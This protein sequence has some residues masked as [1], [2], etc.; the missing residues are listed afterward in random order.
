MAVSRKLFSTS[1]TDLIAE[2]D[3][4]LKECNHLF[5]LLNQ[6]A[7]TI[8]QHI[9]NKQ[10]KEKIMHEFKSWLNE[11]ESYQLH[12][13]KTERLLLTDKDWSDFNIIAKKRD[14]T[15]QEFKQ[16]VNLNLSGRNTEFDNCSLGSM[17]SISSKRIEL[18][19]RQVEL[20]LEKERLEKLHLIE[21]QEADLKLRK[22]QLELEIQMKVAEKK[23][24]V[25]SSFMK[26]PLKDER[27]LND[28]LNQLDETPR[29]PKLLATLSPEQLVFSNT[30]P[31]HIEEPQAAVASSENGV[32]CPSSHDRR[33]QRFAV[34]HIETESLDL[35]QR[36]PFDSQR[37]ANFP[38]ANEHN[39][40]DHPHHSTLNRDESY[41][42]K[43]V[44]MTKVMKRPNIEIKKFD[45]NPLDF[46]RFMRQ[47]KTKIEEACED[48]EERMSFLEQYTTG[49]ANKIVNG[50]ASLEAR[51]GY[52][53]AMQELKERYGDPNII[54][55]SF[56]NKAME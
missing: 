36:N 30:N 13:N 1:N 48:D 6:R 53:Y 15:L 25:L 4:A 11:Y 29:R 19:E 31:F 14:A 17:E 50:Y 44:S 40:G 23:Q 51:H 41:V 16:R 49:H 27:E 12:V 3:Q 52:R 26:E 2:M 18:A 35:N 43:L 32:Q 45:G 9:L 24:R 7:N 22:Q 10:D 54:A 46:N 47:F 28:Q 20:M 55:E 37:V 42:E 21:S 33:E 38:Q 56:I 34:E 39:D 8:D 5:Y